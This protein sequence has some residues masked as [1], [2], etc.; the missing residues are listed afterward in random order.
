MGNFIQMIPRHRFPKQFIGRYNIH[1]RLQWVLSVSKFP[2]SLIKQIPAHAT[3]CVKSLV[4]P[5]LFT[6]NCT[7]AT[8]LLLR[9]ITWKIAVCELVRNVLHQKS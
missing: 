8:S 7:A 2:E 5:M 4:F 1:S 3:T 6:K 9:K